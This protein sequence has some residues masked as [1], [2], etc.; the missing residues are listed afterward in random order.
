MNDDQVWVQLV[1]PG[2]NALHEGA[3]DGRADVEVA[4]LDD[5]QPDQR[6]GEIFNRDFDPAYCWRTAGLVEAITRLRRQSQEEG[7]RVDPGVERGVDRVGQS[8]EQAPGIAQ[9]QQGRADGEEAH[10]EV[11]HP[12]EGVRQPGQVRTGPQAKEQQR[13]KQQKYQSQ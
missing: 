2:D 13:G 3:L 8:Q 9:Y 10:A 11:G 4:D 5:A 1:D 7:R 12:G 6:I